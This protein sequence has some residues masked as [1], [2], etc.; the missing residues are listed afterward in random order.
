[1][2]LNI[3]E[4]LPRGQNCPPLRTNDLNEWCWSMWILALTFTW[5]CDLSKSLNFL[6]VGF[7]IFN[8]KL[9]PTL[10]LTQLVS[11]NEV[12]YVS[13]SIK[14]RAHSRLAAAT[15]FF[16]DIIVWCQSI[17]S[18]LCCLLEI[19]CKCHWAAISQQGQPWAETVVAFSHLEERRST[20]K[21]GRVVFAVL[22]VCFCP[23]SKLPYLQ[24]QDSAK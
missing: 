24:L 11:V 23:A 12:M 7:L 4:C 18:Q 2:S 13:P 1:M 9:V 16:Y 21:S 22:F 5:L 15:I 19:C 14:Y 10:Q 8:V 17:S 20:C 6:S 3:A